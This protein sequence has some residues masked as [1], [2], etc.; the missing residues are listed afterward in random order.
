M[1]SGSSLP[2]PIRRT[3]AD[4][5]RRTDVAPSS[6]DRR[7]VPTVAAKVRRLAAAL[8]LVVGSAVGCDWFDDPSPDEI[9]IRLDGD[10]ETITLITS[11]EFV[12]ARDEAGRMRVQVFGSDTTQISLP[13]DRTWNIREDQRFFMVGIPA[14]SAGVP[15]R[16]RVHLDGDE[17]V[18]NNVL[19]RINTPV[20]FMYIFNQQI[21]QEFELL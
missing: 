20:R 15:M 1:G 12:A 7:T 8:C 13:F 4:S 5:V 16:L 11:T 17:S 18:D 3:G 2:G 19:A 6:P 14:D 9:R 10:A 21:L